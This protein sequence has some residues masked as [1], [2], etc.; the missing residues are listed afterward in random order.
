MTSLMVPKKISIFVAA[1]AEKT[2][3]KTS[4][5]LRTFRCATIMSNS[6]SSISSPLTQ[7]RSR[8]NLI[9]LIQSRRRCQSNAECRCSSFVYTTCN[10][11]KRTRRRKRLSCGKGAV[12]KSLGAWVGP[13]WVIWRL[14]RDCSKRHR[15]TRATVWT[16]SPCKFQ[17]LNKE[18]SVCL[19]RFPPPG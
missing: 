19:L 2:S 6:L 17:G 4:H 9:F 3:H 12:Q 11:R 13:T 10:A 18:I 16:K 15:W 7:F 5:N 14:P 8:L 1:E